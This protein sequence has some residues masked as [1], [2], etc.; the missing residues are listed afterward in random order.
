VE[1]S[2]L[3]LAAVFAVAGFLVL[4]LGII[5]AL[6]FRRQLRELRRRRRRAVLEPI[7]LRY[8]GATEG[9]LLS[10]L[11]DP[12]PRLDR[13]VLEWILRD[14]IQAVRGSARERL[15][16]AFDELGLVDTYVELLQKGRPWVRAD[17]AEKLGVMR[18][19]R[20]QEPLAR[21][22]DDPAP[23]VRIRAAKALGLIGGRGA[24]A[25]LVS[26]LMKPNLWSALRIADIL[27]SM[28]EES[29]TGLIDEI[30]K[31]PPASR[32]FVI[33]IFGRVRSLRAIPM[34]R[35]QLRDPEPDVR[36]RAAHALGQIGDP[37]S[38]PALLLALHDEAWP[39]RA[40]SAKALGRI[41][42]NLQVEGLC[43]VLTDSQWW[44]R[45]N[46]AEA[47]KSKG[48][49]GHRALIGILD[50]TDAYAREQAVFALEESGVLDD[51][52]AKLNSEDSTERERAHALVKHLV[53]LDRTDHL[54]DMIADH[55]DPIIRQNLAGF[56]DPMPARKGA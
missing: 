37:G 20:A 7:V 48:E 49:A 35:E 9:T 55:P 2:T 13:E 34:L 27:A 51:Y 32:L 40:M 41:P 12:P 6:K 46:A 29:V 52:V 38:V 8:S 47:L 28:G 14:H 53:R 10:F 4:L 25:K 22:M 11:G 17:A 44:V 23:E 21:A 3:I 50:S 45:A 43:S 54:Q 33:D 42:G 15:I 18:S 26:A 19:I 36:A 30:H 16:R 24:T 5:I 39:V 56:L 31:I 1:R